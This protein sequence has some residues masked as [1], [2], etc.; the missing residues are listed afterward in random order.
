MGE[1]GE[2]TIELFPADKKGSPGCC[3]NQ[4]RSDKVTYKGKRGD[5]R[6]SEEVLRSVPE[7][8]AQLIALVTHKVKGKV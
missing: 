4:V 5:Q 7:V 6:T 8:R 2:H 1:V 3:D